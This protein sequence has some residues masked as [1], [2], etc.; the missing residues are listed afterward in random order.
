M[1]PFSARYHVKS[2]A[3]AGPTRPD[4]SLDS[5]HDADGDIGKH[6]LIARVLAMRHRF[7]FV[8]RDLDAFKLAAC[9]H[10]GDQGG[11]GARDDAAAR[12]R[13][14]LPEPRRATRLR[15]RRDDTGSEAVPEGAQAGG[16]GGTAARTRT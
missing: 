7:A 14:E 11:E 12:E 3:C 10:V 1:T 16:S 5:V 15:H 13:R 2:A 6:D 9:A 4:G 8:N